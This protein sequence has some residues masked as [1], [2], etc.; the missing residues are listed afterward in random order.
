M[1]K[2]IKEG[3]A[4]FEM[5]ESYPAKVQRTSGLT[6]N[7]FLQTVIRRN[8]RCED[9]AKV[10][11]TERGYIIQKEVPLK[12]FVELNPEYKH[13]LRKPLFRK[14]DTEVKFNTVQLKELQGCP[15][16]PNC[17]REL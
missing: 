5:S 11:F 2:Y 16:C 10:Q 3:I 15:D 14:P 7:V 1:Y 12:Q 4:T 9:S 13:L 8:N 17:I 6:T